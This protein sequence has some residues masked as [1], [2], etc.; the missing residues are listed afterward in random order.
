VDLCL[1]SLRTGHPPSCSDASFLQAKGPCL[2]WGP[3]RIEDAHTRDE[4]ISVI[5]LERSVDVLRTFLTD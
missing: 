2:V 1:R 4:R 3:G 5:E